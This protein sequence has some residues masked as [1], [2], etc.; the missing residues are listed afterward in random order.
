M[1]SKESILTDIVAKENLEEKV[2]F[3]LGFEEWGGV[4]QAVPGGDGHASFSQEWTTEQDTH[5]PLGKAQGLLPALLFLAMQ[6][7]LPASFQLA[8]PPSPQGSSKAGQLAMPSCPV[9]S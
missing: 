9:A 3:E 1:F 4:R 5:W 8:L 2:G 6:S 7:L